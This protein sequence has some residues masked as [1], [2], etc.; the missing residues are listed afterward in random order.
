VDGA[1]TLGGDVLKLFQNFQAV[2][3]TLTRGQAVNSLAGVRLRGDQ[4]RFTVGP[5]VYTGRVTGDTMAGTVQTGQKTAKWTA[6]KLL[7]E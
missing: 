1:W 3:G 5:S 4:I 7:P 2:S 6:K